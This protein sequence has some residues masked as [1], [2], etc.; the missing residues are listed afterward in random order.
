[1]K[2]LLCIALSILL[3]LSMF[4]ACGKD[5]G[6]QNNDETTG[7]FSVGYGK[8]DISP[9]HPVYLRGYGS[10]IDKQLVGKM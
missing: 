7:V 1:M 6:A 4:G 9:E 3:A 8:A 10:I 2:R 5:G